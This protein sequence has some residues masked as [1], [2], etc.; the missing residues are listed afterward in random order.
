MRPDILAL[1][2]HTKRQ[3]SELV[4]EYAGSLDAQSLPT[5]LQIKIKNILEAERSALDYL[6]NHLVDRYGDT[7]KPAHLIQFPIATNHNDFIRRL[8]RQ[9][10]G[11][12]VGH[13]VIS[14]IES[15]QP[16]T[17]GA[18]VNQLNEATNTLKHRGLIPMIRTAEPRKV[19]QGVSWGTGVSFGG[20]VAINGSLVDPVTQRTVDGF[21]RDEVWV[22][23]LIDGMNV[24]ARGTAEQSLRGI[25]ELLNELERVTAQHV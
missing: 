11:I 5:G 6:A 17:N 8:D 7:S 19:H 25:H 23:W 4:T 12:P 20:G 3:L 13:P 16:F 14:V 2:E 1:L 22:D 15:A 21:T 18:W 9:L 10:P 24:S